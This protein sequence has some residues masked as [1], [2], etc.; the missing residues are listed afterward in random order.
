M[1]MVRAT[2]VVMEMAMKASIKGLRGSLRMLR[3]HCDEQRTS[4]VGSHPTLRALPSR[5]SE[6]GGTPLSR[7]KKQSIFSLR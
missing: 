1:L 2:V 7:R 3:R 4:Q 6:A 5:F